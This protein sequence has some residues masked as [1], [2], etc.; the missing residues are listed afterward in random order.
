MERVPQELLDL[1]D[2][3]A[4]GFIS[5]RELF[6]RAARFAVGGL[7]VAA[8]VESVMPRY[9]EAQQI[10]EDDQR[11]TGERIEYP[12]PKGAG[13]MG[14]Y[15]VRPG[16]AEG[17]LPGVV[18]IHENRGLNPH[19]ADVA[20][21]AALE[22]YLA[23]APDALFPLGGYPGS[24]DEGREL[25][26]Q[27]DRAEM[28]QDFIAAVRWLQVHPMCTGEVACIGFCF[29]GSMTNL[30]AVRIADLAA[31]VPFY[32]G[33]PALDEVEKIEAPLLLH[34]G[35]LDE[36]VNEGWPAYEEALKAAG[37]EYTAHFYPGANHGFH[38]DT[39]PR[40]DEEAAKLA[41][42]RTVEFLAEHLK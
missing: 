19:I 36:R 21:R 16:E 24:D 9:A 33:Q 22:G 1:Y 34:F 35:E 14:A 11:V 25:Q 4:H 2:R 3:Y 29:G 12:S 17:E 32:G 23:M 10:R 20:R 28:E 13:T 40:Y 15:L 30:M 27:R 6:D 7:T 37:K 39:T 18:V 31:A 38:N 8:V 41:W 5:R 42:S 26:R